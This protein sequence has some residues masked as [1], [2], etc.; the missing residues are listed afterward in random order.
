MIYICYDRDNQSLLEMYLPPLCRWRVSM[1][2]N[3]VRGEWLRDGLHSKKGEGIDAQKKGIERGVLK[4]LD[5]EKMGLGMCASH[6]LFLAHGSLLLCHFFHSHPA[7]TLASP[8][9]PPPPSLAVL[10]SQHFFQRGLLWVVRVIIAFIIL[11]YKLS[12]LKDISFL[13][14]ASYNGKLRRMD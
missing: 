12:V 13:L 6:S 7:A 3:R 4:R 11:L 10:P 2:G 9:P 1:E 14:Q 8:P 5:G